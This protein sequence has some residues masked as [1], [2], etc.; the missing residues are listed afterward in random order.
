MARNGT[1]QVR[2][3]QRTLYRTAK[4]SK[5]VKF[6][7]LYDKVWRSDVLWEAWKQVKENQGAPGVDGETIEGIVSR[8]EEGLMLSRLQEQLRAKTYH[9][10]PVRRVDIP[11]PKGGTRP[12][13]I[14]TVEDRVVQTAMKL[15]LEPIFEADFHD[16]SYGYR[17][18]RDAKMASKAIRNDLY[19]GAWSVVEIDFRSYFTTIPHDKLMILIK[20]RVVDGS[21]LRLIKQS[22]T[23]EIAYEG[24]V[25]PTTVGVPQGSPI[26]PLYSNIYLNLLDQVWH[27]RSYPEKLGATLHRY[28]DDGVPRARKAARLSSA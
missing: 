20:Q 15:V 19:R 3:L 27:R 5:A 9:F 23:V 10:H 14:A 16:C 4:Q 8:G 2:Q 24:K 26:S 7:S 13:G 21:M 22:L 12:L 28:A 17:P 11:K 25:E 1:E 6:Y 18:R